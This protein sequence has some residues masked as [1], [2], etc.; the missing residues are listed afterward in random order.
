MTGCS[1]RR[2]TGF[3]IKWAQAAL[4]SRALHGPWMLRFDGLSM[5]C[6]LASRL[7]PLLPTRVRRE[8]IMSE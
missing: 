7:L 5:A 6:Q 2:R 4:P 8:K 3:D 1:D